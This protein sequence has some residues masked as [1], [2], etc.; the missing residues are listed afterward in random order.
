[1]I[2][3]IDRDGHQTAIAICLLLFR[4]AH[5]NYPG[6]NGVGMTPVDAEKIFA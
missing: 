6:A 4:S 1:M 5:R 3:P 2:P